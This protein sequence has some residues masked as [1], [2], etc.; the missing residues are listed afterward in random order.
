MTRPAMASATRP[1]TPAAVRNRLFRG[2]PRGGARR[3]AQEGVTDGGEGHQTGRGAGRAAEGL[4]AHQQDDRNQ[5]AAERRPADH[6]AHRI[7]GLPLGGVLAGVITGS[8]H[9]R[10]PAGGCWRWYA[11]LQ[12]R[13]GGLGHWGV[14]TSE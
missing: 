3:L 13:P 14:G 11:V 7:G 5:D 12:R 9:E 2:D 10:L 8:G 4:T 1:A 6:V